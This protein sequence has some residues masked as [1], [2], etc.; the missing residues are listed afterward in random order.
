MS[1][2]LQTLS[3]LIQSLGFC[4]CWN[5]VVQIFLQSYELTHILLVNALF[6]NYSENFLKMS[7]QPKIFS[8]S[9]SVHVNTISM[10]VHLIPSIIIITYLHIFLGKNSGVD[11]FLST[12]A[13][14]FGS[15]KR[16]VLCMY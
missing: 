1:T 16:R 4:L 9:D 11:I 15:W 13:T 10:F 6:A 7:L 12:R 8:D 2:V 3:H 14:G 5:L